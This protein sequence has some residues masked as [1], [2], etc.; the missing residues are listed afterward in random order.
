MSQYNYTF[1]IYDQETDEPVDTVTVEAKNYMEAD[2]E[3]DA[4]LDD[5]PGLCISLGGAEKIEPISA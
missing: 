1:T 3:V 2:G 4:W 5:H